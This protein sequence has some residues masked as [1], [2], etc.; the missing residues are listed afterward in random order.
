MSSPTKSVCSI[1]RRRCVSVVRSMWSYHFF[2]S[3]SDPLA[4][5]EGHLGCKDDDLGHDNGYV[6]E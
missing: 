1:P 2:F 4:V 5:V 3:M 6:Y